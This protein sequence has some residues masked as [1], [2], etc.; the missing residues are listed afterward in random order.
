MSGAADR[1][2]DAGLQAERTALA[3]RRTGLAM[4]VAA[5]GAGRLAAPVIGALAVALAGVGLLQAVS[6]SLAARRRYRAT[7]RSLTSRADL[8]ALRQGGWPMATLAG[9]CLTVGLLALAFVVGA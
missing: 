8:A 5:V 9:S 6:V 1:V 2:F 3:W 4:A 7:H